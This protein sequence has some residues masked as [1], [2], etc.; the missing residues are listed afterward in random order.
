M[1]N[2][3]PIPDGSVDELPLHP[4]LVENP[5]ADCDF[6]PRDNSNPSSASSQSAT[7]SQQAQSAGV[8]AHS[9]R[10]YSSP[11]PQASVGSP[12]QP[13]NAKRSSP[14]NDRYSESSYK[15]PK[16]ADAAASSQPHPSQPVVAV[17]GNTVNVTRLPLLS[18]YSHHSL[19]KLRP[20]V[21]AT[22]LHELDMFEIL[23][24]P[25]LRHDLVFD[26]HLQFRPST[27][28]D[29][30]VRKR[31]RARRFWGWV[32]AR[33]TGRPFCYFHPPPPPGLAPGEF[34]SAN[35]NM[36]GCL[37]SMYTL[38]AGQPQY[39]HIGQL[40]EELRAVIACVLP[41]TDQEYSVLVQEVLD[42]QL[43][44]QQ[45]EH[46]VFDARSITTF[47][48]RL[49]K[50]HCAPIRDELLERMVKAV[51]AGEWICGLS[52]CFEILEWMRLDIANHQ[53]R[54]LRPYLVESAVEFERQFF[55]GQLQ[56][57]AARLTRTELWLHD[58]VELSGGMYDSKTLTR[59]FN[60]YLIS[61]I[62]TSPEN[63]TKPLPETFAFDQQR[64]ASYHSDFEDLAFLASAFFLTSHL[65][66]VQNKRLK[67][68]LWPLMIE[69]PKRFDKIAAAMAQYGGMS[70]AFVE[71]WIQRNTG[72]VPSDMARLVRER[73]RGHLL[74]LVERGTVDTAKLAADGLTVV[75][76][77]ILAM[78]ERVR[79]LSEFHRAV[80]GPIYKDLIDRK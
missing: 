8:G 52:M 9:Q 16:L 41:T 80:Y 61:L 31:E 69:R 5:R 55:T 58:L 50:L 71:G 47:M 68:T 11:A 59:V 28:G 15:R 30:G 60:E 32:E 70:A 44:V 76:E 40:I 7:S 51:E 79:K 18:P 56:A 17:S 53:L 13:K 12:K 22:T 75:R 78:G 23:K 74:S 35:E 21:T 37:P 38:R 57:S 45:L 46:G 77:E 2:N 24:N 49:L 65:A 72:P 33:A 3:L 19:P 34:Y 4:L 26:P 66:P 62:S 1:Q 20:P 63:V 48:A 64:L 39:D 54:T 14:S 29:A 36:C 73:L 43:V 10:R 25:Q 6:S 67:H 27:E 42:P